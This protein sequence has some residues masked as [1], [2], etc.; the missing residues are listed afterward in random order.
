MEN[1]AK[2]IQELENKCAMQEQQIAELTAKVNWF[3]EQFRLSQQKKYG[4]SSEQ[5]PGQE[6]LQ[7]FNEAESLANPSAPEPEL[8]E[9]TYKRR[10][11]KGQR[12]AKLEDLPVETI[13]YHLPADEQLCSCCN[14]E[15]HEMSKEVRR[16]IKV[17]PAQVSVVKHVRYTY[18]CR[19][20][21]QENTQ[22]A[23]VTAPM[24]AP[25]LPGSL[26]SPSAIAHTMNQK[27]VEAM[28][29]YRQEKAWERMGVELSRQTLANWIIQAAERW[30]LPLYKRMHEFLLQEDILHSDESH[31]QVLQEPDRPATSKS[32]LWLYRTGR[33][34]PP[35]VLYEYQ[36]TR[37]NK[38][39]KK[40][41]EGFKGYLHV[42]GY[43]GY[44][45]I[46]DV[47]LVGC[48]SH[49]RRKFDE[50]LKALP[51]DKR[52]ADVAAKKGLAFCNRLFDIERALKDTTSSERYKI[53]LEQSK[54]V[55]DE[56]L[57]W[58]KQQRPHV[59][60]KSSFGQAITYCLNQWEKLEAFLQDGRL[61]LDNNRAE[62]S[63]KPF[64]I[65]R[66][67]WLFSNTPRG[68]RASAAVYS[69]VETAKE[70]GLNPFHY[71]QYL[72][73]KMPNLDIQDTE[74]L[75]ELLPWSE[76]L[77]PGCRVKS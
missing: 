58:L 43:S 9:I 3:E 53:R 28:P 19:R 21:E 38:H 39:P 37:A 77:P 56:F 25:A 68:A 6:Q 23:I 73:E 33:A 65:G 72:F 12:E 17:I 30:L 20:C 63:I 52:T 70:N 57:A 50:A 22:N 61:E 62:R 10:K 40:F 59:L 46:P 4:R 67:N 64:V 55:L 32:F 69:I 24:P 7:I 75:D 66:K 15:L 26:A 49:A 47:I 54:P 44:N 31:L 8:E 34:S 41:L 18:A 13:E 11:Q 76:A 29:L 51:K 60:P 48:W 5:A 16:E 2:K 35:V 45:E 1:T 71:L 27:Y 36:T 74:V 42:D 14:N